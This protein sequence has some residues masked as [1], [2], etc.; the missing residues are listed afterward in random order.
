MFRIEVL[1]YFVGIALLG[2]IYY[3]LK[4]FIENDWLFVLSIV[5]YLGVVRAFGYVLDK[6]TQREKRFWNKVRSD[7]LPFVSEDDVIVIDPDGTEKSGEVICLENTTDGKTY[8]VE[9]A[10]GSDVI[11]QSEAMRLVTDNAT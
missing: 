11:V 5:L 2:A 7:D 1:V 8:I 4:Y 10:D 3:P 6:P 9:L